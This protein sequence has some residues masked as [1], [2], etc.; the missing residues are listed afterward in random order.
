VRRAD[1]IV[2]LEGGRIVEAGSHDELMALDGR[3][4]RMFDLQARYYTET[5]ESAR[6]AAP[7]RP[8]RKPAKAAQP[9]KAVKAPRAAEPTKGV[10]AVKAVKAVEPAEPVGA[11][12]W[13]DWELEYPESEYA[14]AREPH[15][16]SPAHTYGEAP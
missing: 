14:D 15:L 7:A 1:K 12:D 4:A 5:P 2:V 9:T 3:Y 8:A 16:P 13:D 11:G 6:S 10:K